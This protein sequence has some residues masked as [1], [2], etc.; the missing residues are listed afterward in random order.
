MRVDAAADAFHRTAD[1]QESTSQYV[2]ENDPE[3]M[4]TK[5]QRPAKR[6]PGPSLAIG[7]ALGAVVA[8]LCSKRD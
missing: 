6:Y 8:K 2:K 5:V 1:R 4:M 3:A 7:I